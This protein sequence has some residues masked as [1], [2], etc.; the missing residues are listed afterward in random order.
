MHVGLL[1]APVFVFFLLVNIFFYSS[2]SSSSSPWSSS[3]VMNDRPSIII[4]VNNHHLCLHLNFHHHL[5][6]HLYRHHH[7]LLHYRLF[8]RFLVFPLFSDF[9]SPPSLF[10]PLPALRVLIHQSACILCSCRVVELY[11]R[12]LENASLTNSSFRP[13]LRAFITHAFNKRKRSDNR[14]HVIWGAYDNSIGSV[15]GLAIRTLI[16]CRRLWTK[17]LFGE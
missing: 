8:L 9:L 11:R 17:T 7:C 5:S 12:E 13:L 14:R 15:N 1:D 2:L 6:P 4:S 3:S 10:P 16:V